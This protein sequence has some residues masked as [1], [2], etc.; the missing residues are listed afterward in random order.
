LGIH[1]EFKHSG[2]YQY[3]LEQNGLT[4]D[5]IAESIEKIYNNLI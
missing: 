1:D 2:D 3:N 5:C 4:P